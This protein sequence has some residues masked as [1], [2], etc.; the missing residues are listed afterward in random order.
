MTN[1]PAHAHLNR[2]SMRAIVRE[3]YGTADVCRHRHTP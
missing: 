1:D 2:I 3:G